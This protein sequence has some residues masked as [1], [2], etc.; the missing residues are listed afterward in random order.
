MP[1][2]M[3]GRDPRHKITG[4]TPPHLTIA[5]KGKRQRLAHVAWIGG[6]KGIVWLVRHSC[7]RTVREQDRP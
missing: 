5:G 4:L 6:A 1:D 3:V 2:Q 7:R